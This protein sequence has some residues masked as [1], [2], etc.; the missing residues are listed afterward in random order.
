MS[1][2]LLAAG[3]STR[4]GRQKALLAW[5]GS[6]LLEYQLAQLAAVDEIREIIVVTGHDP[7]RITAIASAAARTRVAHN[8][9]YRTGKV[10]SITAGL[11]TVSSGADAIL[12]LGVDQPR[13]A[14]I[15]RAV[16]S[17]YSGSRAPITVPAH[18]GRAGHPALFDAA[19]L[20]ELTAI[21]E[22]T[23]GIRAVRQ[24]YAAETLAV[25]LGDPAVNLDL[26]TPADLGATRNL[27]W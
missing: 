25:E 10:S 19:L 15:V 3:E 21:T 24:R 18:I 9:A 20:P 1:A 2:I 16:V 11:A 4:M 14:D 7:E 17:A 12:L 13:S 5:E 23:Q 22:E 6:T 8:A 27:L 26:N